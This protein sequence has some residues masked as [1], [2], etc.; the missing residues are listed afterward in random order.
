MAN[1]ARLNLPLVTPGANG[2]EVKHN[3][4]L[5]LIDQILCL[6]VVQFDLNTPPGGPSNGQA[7]KIGSSPTGAW[8]A[9]ADDI[10]IYS[11]GWNFVSVADGM[12]LHDDTDD[13]LYVCHDAA[14]DTW[15]KY[16][17]QC[18]DVGAMTDSTGGSSSST[19]SAVSGT[20]DD[21]G[22]NN[23]LASLTAQLNAIR[24]SMRNADLMA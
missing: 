3:D 10:A 20:G 5:R 6:S 1:T 18:A 15:K 17:S 12:V 21:S 8:A 19:I 23:A 16:G 4:M 11:S 14:T 7:W 9:N 22:I 13:V 24:T 2:G